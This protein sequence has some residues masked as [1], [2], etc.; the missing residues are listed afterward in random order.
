MPLP[1]QN[2]S[3]TVFGVILLRKP[4]SLGRYDPYTGIVTA[5]RM[6]FAQMTSDMLKQA[7]QTAK[8][9]AKADGKGFWGQMKDQFSAW[10][11]YSQKYL[12]MDP[13]A[14]LS[15]TLG[16]FAVNNNTISEIKI[17][18]KELDDENSSQRELEMKVDSTQGKY[19]FRLEEKDEYV[20]LLKQVYGERVK[21][22]FGYLSSSGVRVKLF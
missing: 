22:P 15:E 18:L 11:Y 10:Y 1:A 7:S 5:Q 2:F 6:I 4:K 9:Q 21:M 12:I 19:E 13:S 16:N 3:E 8:E 20:N 17:K 14:A